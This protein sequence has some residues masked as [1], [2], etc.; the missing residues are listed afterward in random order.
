[1][2]QGRGS[3]SWFL[4]L[5]SAATTTLQERENILHGVELLEMNPSFR[6]YELPVVDVSSYNT[7]G[8]WIE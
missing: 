7:K 5:W 6:D 3:S 2:V 8:P 1:M 4:K